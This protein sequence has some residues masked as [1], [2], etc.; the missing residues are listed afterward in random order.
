MAGYTCCPAIVE[1]TGWPTAPARMF[2]CRNGKR[3]YLKHS[4]LAILLTLT[5]SNNFGES[6]STVSA[7]LYYT[8]VM[9]HHY[10]VAVLQVFA[11]V[12]DVPIFN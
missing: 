5:S 6:Q 2:D 12:V 3:A 8:R 7:M 11:V 10:R 1:G 4:T 9:S